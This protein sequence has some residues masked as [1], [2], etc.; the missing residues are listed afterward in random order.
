MVPAV[1]APWTTPHV[2]GSWASQHRG[3]SPGPLFHLAHLGS[4]RLVQQTLLRPPVPTGPAVASAGAFLQPR[5]QLGEEPT[6]TWRVRAEP[7]SSSNTAIRLASSRSLGAEG[8]VRGGLLL[9]CGLQAGLLA[10]PAVVQPG[11][12]GRVLLRF[13]A[14]VTDQDTQARLTPDP[15]PAGPGFPRALPAAL[16]PRTQGLG[17]RDGWGASSGLL[18][19]GPR[20]PK[21]IPCGSSEADSTSLRPGDVGRK[22][23]VLCVDTC[24]LTLRSSK[25]K[26]EQG[27][28]GARP[29]LGAGGA[30]DMSWP[31]RSRGLG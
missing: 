6:R 3:A 10:W 15:H 26:P 23:G 7:A 1:V 20:H 27:F 16:E 19:W 9:P 17:P 21:A 30:G 5:G 22:D 4:S 8:R 24:S 29:R 31:E 14:S 25:T 12:P 2:E 11:K 13:T 18:S 28:W